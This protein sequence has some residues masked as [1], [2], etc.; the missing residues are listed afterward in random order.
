MISNLDHLDVERFDQ[1]IEQSLS[2]QE[3]ERAETHLAE[4]RQC[5]DQLAERAGAHRWWQ[6]ASKY[7]EP[8]VDESSTDSPR[9]ASQSSIELE[10]VLSI[11]AP[12]DDPR[13]IG[14]IGCYEVAGVIGS[15]G[16]GIVLKGFDVSLNRYVAIKLLRPTLAA[17]AN[18]RLRF[19]REGQAVASVLHENVIA[20]H[21]VDESNGLPYLVMPYIRGESLG[22]RVTRNGPMKLQE[23]LRI[24]YQVAS[25]LAAAHAQ[26]LI[27]RDVK[28][29]NI[30]IE[31]GVERLKLTD[32]GLA[33][34]VDDVG[35]TKSGTLT[36]TPEYM[37]PEQA[38]GE[39]VDSRSDLFSLGS[40]LWTL[41]AGRPPFVADSCYGVIRRIIESEPHPLRSIDPSLPNWFA[42][43]VG[44]LM[45]KSADD[46]IQSATK[47]ASLLEQ[48]LAHV[49]NS[50]APLPSEL[51]ASAKGRSVGR[52]KWSPQS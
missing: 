51:C 12:T 47:L 25:G 2:D 20:I 26:G 38:K 34:A 44:R 31:A 7:L 39:V 33:R 11:L 29:S 22:T 40:V 48:T 24:G 18:S 1:L 42:E 9:F 19:A 45:E 28:P 5:R 15:G 21:G 27:H 52:T 8:S 16:M 17:S 30:L 32:F 3:H 6:A 50:D 4:C 46:R 49:Q 23:I 36:G 41:A 14:R 37:S 35:L 10:Q 43:L 13:M